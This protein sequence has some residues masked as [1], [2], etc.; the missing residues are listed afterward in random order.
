MKRLENIRELLEY[1]ANQYNNKI[2][3]TIDQ[4]ITYKQFKEKVDNL[5]NS[6][7]NQQ[8][9]GKRIAI[10]SENRYEWELTFFAI[11]NGVG[12]VVP[13]DKSLPVQEIKNI[14]EQTNVEL[15]FTSDE[16]LEELEEID[17]KQI[18][19]DGIEFSEM[20]A[21]P[22]LANKN[23]IKV[24]SKEDECVIISTS[25]T[26]NKSKAVILTQNNI[27]SNMLNVSEIMEITKEDIAL[28]V[29]PLNH[30]LE[31]LFCMLLTI[32]KGAT[33]I[34][35]SNIDDIVDYIKKYKITYMGAVPAIYEYLYEKIDEWKEN[36]PQINIFMSGGAP[37][38]NEIIRKYKEKGINLIQGYGM[39]EAAPVIS[40]ETIENNKLC[41]VGK[42][43]PN[44][45]VKIINQN[46][47][48][49]GEILVKGE[50]ITKGYLNNEIETKNAIID[51]WLHTGDLGKID[52]EGCIFITGRINNMIVLSNGKKV[53]PEEI[54]ALINNT[55]GVKESVVYG[56]KKINAKIS[57]NN[58]K[59][60][61]Q[62]LQE[63]INKINE[64]LP[65]YKRI[66]SI[67]Y[68]TE[69]LD[70][71]YLGKIKRNIEKNDEKDKFSL[72]KEIIIEQLDIDESSI[73]LDS[74]LRNDLGA[75]SLDKLAIFLKVENQFNIKIEKEQRKLVKT[76][77]DLFKII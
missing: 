28:S 10:I 26:T 6:L 18:S 47:D 42:A 38:K 71:T 63:K 19:F 50:N 74:D 61:E 1:C 4:K 72:L 8:Y 54:E 30:V 51:G 9:E 36:I 3:Y 14:V 60:S 58:N 62:Q 64:Q 73:K 7:I 12:T 53:F 27:I 70:K 67:E 43:I 39:T 46:E 41:S 2:L 33:R 16:Y 65:I 34:H 31:G 55:E 23:E 56:T 32:Y 49:I 17:I 52:E 76:V 66:Q 48:G 68:T 45:Q 5:S 77:Q 11:C 29:M 37:L 57:Y 69:D 44:V 59:I 15:I 35:C 13:I 22:I 75:D 21:N 20:V 24:I 25:G 40:M